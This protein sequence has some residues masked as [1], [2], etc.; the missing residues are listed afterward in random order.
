M[1]RIRGAFALFLL[2]TLV[3]PVACAARGGEAVGRTAFPTR[4]LHIIAPAAPGGGWDQTARAMQAALA[5]G[6]G[7]NVLVYNVPGAGG[8]VGLAQFAHDHA[9][10]PHQLLV[11]GLVM[12]GATY[13]NRSP[14][15]LEQVTPV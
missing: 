13:T 11:G 9:G 2:P 10:D 8:T 14:V 4:P 3:L 7:R 1:N 12:L 6:T 5:E 15:T